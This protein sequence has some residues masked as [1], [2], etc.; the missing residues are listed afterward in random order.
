MDVQHHV[1]DEDRKPE[2]AERA[3]RDRQ[4]AEDAETLRVRGPQRPADQVSAPPAPAPE[5]VT[6]KANPVTPVK[7]RPTEPAPVLVPPA[8]AKA[9]S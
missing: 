4:A 7:V 2:N 6:P 9:E 1:T 5:P 8:P 3:L